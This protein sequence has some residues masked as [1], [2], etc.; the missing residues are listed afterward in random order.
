MSGAGAW[1]ASRMEAGAEVW[2]GHLTRPGSG[3]RRQLSAWML[4]STGFLVRVMLS[5]L[6]VLGTEGRF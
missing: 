6:G 1:P 3:T 4:G 5:W 2:A